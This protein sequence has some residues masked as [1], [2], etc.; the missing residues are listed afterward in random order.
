M[1]VAGDV[2]TLASSKESS[3][4]RSGG[5]LVCFDFRLVSVETLEGISASPELRIVNVIG[6]ESL[7]EQACQSPGTA[8]EPVGPPMAKELGC[9]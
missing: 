7:G 6:G 9:R 5:H 4:G 1:A 3:S 2:I 8:E